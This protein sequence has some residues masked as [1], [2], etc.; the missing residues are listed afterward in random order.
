MTGASVHV[1]HLLCP[2]QLM[3]CTSGRRSH[4]VEKTLET[5]AG[6]PSLLWVEQENFISVE[7]IARGSAFGQG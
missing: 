7:S 1:P 4:D 6:A 5:S 2:N 3:N